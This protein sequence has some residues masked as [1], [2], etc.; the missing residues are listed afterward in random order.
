M[1]DIYKRLCQL[2]KDNLAQHNSTTKLHFERPDGLSASIFNYPQ[3]ELLAIEDNE[4]F[5]REC[6]YKILDRPVDQAAFKSLR[7][8]LKTKRLSKQEVIQTIY[9]SEERVK[10]Q[11]KLD[12]N[13][14]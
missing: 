13:Q 4:V 6:F 8:A 7:R 14:Q 10:K 3:S 12:F 11:T 5:I 2:T 1:I 9:D